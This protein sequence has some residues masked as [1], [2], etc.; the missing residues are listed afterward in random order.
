MAVFLVMHAHN[1]PGMKRE[2]I[3]NGLVSAMI[4]HFMAATTSAS[5]QRLA[6]YLGD[7]DVNDQLVCSGVNYDTMLTRVPLHRYESRVQS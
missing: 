1:I 4:H 3:E 2:K 7:D 6:S 5:S